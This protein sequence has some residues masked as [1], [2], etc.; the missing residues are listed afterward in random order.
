M[1]NDLYEALPAGS[2]AVQAVLFGML[3]IFYTVHAT[4][5]LEAQEGGVVRSRPP[6]AA[7]LRCLSR[8]TAWLGALPM[9]TAELCFS[10]LAQGYEG[11][12][13]VAPLGLTTVGMV[14][15]GFFVAYRLMK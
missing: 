15:V 13:I 4:F 10:H 7:I 8:L 2:L 11:F 12:W 9:L 14:F 1:P 5:S 6:A 3:G